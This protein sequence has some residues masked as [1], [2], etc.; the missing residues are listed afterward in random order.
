MAATR[1][2]DVG[3]QVEGTR[4]AVGHLQI[5]Y[6]L[7]R[8]TLGVN[9]FFHGAMRLITG[10]SAW[11]VTQAELFVDTL[12]PMPLVHAFLYALPFIEVVLGVFTVLGLYTNWALIGGALMMLVLLFGNTTRQA[13]ATA[14]NNMHYVLYYY[15]LIVRQC[16]NW[17]AL[18]NRRSRS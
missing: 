12:L 13:W 9:I 1:A 6:A 3:R 7:F 8:I 17:L 14:G 5:G 10:L 4:G 16:D 11:E 2:M 15:I 18:D